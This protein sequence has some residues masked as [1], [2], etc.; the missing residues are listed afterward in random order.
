[1]LKMTEGFKVV[2]YFIDRLDEGEEVN[3]A[4]VFVAIDEG[5]FDNLTYY[6][7]IGQ[8]SEGAREYLEDCTP[9]TKEEYLKVSG[10]LYTPKDYL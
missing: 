10:H 9:I 6:C 3:S 4:T 7:P 2:G 8:H 1:M 5:R